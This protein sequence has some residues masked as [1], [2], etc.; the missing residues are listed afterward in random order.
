M[1][2]EGG[3]LGKVKAARLAAFYS[4]HLLRCSAFHPWMGVWR[5]T[6]TPV[7]PSWTNTE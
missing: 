4:L 6:G 1:G 7:S 3:K 5:L 2:L